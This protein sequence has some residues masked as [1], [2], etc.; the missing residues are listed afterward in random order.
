MEPI[1]LA[2]SSPRRQEILKSL[3]IPYTV[4][5]P[6][7]EEEMPEKGDPAEL[8]ELNAMKKLSAAMKVAGTKITAKWILSADTLISQ[9]GRIFGK[10]ADKEKAAAMLRSF[11]GK[12]HE[13]VTA[14]CFF[15][16][17]TNYVSTRIS[18][19]KISFID[20][21]EETIAKYFEIGEWQGAAGAYKIQGFA[22]C[23]IKN[24]E[25]SY[26]GAVGLP[27]HLLYEL[28]LEHKYDFIV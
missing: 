13:I 25:G 12:E 2:S 16:G 27:V 11:S 3:E 28:L 24:M 18:R 22:A 15:S 1:I 17:R 10:P 8:A 7:C 19:T 26:S 21:T 4:V 5:I 6:D 23:F 9:D 14:L 20:L